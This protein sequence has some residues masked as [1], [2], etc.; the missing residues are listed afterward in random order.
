VTADACKSARKQACLDVASTAI[1]AGRK[2]TPSLAEGCVTATQSTY[3]SNNAVITPAQQ[4]QLSDTCARVFAG[5]VA[6]GATCTSS[7]DCSGSMI[8]DKG[9]CGD[10]VEKKSGDGCAN[11]GEVCETGTF[12]QPQTGASICVARVA[13]GKVCDATN[14]CLESLRCASNCVDRV[15]ARGA[16]QSNGDCASDAPYCDPAAGNIC[17]PG[18][19]FAFGAA[20][21]H[22]YGA[23]GGAPPPVDA[24]ATT[25]AATD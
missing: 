12:C 11:P 9:H 6:K 17:T 21:C 5:A 15:G 3:S 20:D 18:L 13:A 14:L 7:Y 25:D 19:S 2:Y 10:K 8:C 1:Q 24:G 23:P 16:C 4:L 22:D